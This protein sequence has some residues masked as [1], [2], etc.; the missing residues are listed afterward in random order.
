[1]TSVIHDMFSFSHDIL[2][3]EKHLPEVIKIQIILVGKR[4]SRMIRY[5]NKAL[6]NP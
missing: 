4:E 1:M 3:A 6:T 2:R 5:T